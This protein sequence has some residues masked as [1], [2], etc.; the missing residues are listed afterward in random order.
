[1]LNQFAEHFDPVFRVSSSNYCLHN[2]LLVQ[3]DMGRETAFLCPPVLWHCLHA[4]GR[5]R[6]GGGGWLLR[7][8]LPRPIRLT[9]LV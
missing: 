4:K 6:G 5:P 7:A 3:Q 9:P 2:D 1:M 8:P